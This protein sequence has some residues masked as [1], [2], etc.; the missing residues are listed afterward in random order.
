MDRV[1]SGLH[2]F[3]K[4]K[5]KGL[6]IGTAVAVVGLG[7]GAGLLLNHGNSGGTESNGAL[8]NPTVVSSNEKKTVTREDV[9]ISSLSNFDIITPKEAPDGFADASDGWNDKVDGGQTTEGPD[10]MWFVSDNFSTEG[11]VDPVCDVKFAIHKQSDTVSQV[12]EVWHG[13]TLDEIVE[14]TQAT[15]DITYPNRSSI[16]VTQEKVTD[17]KIQS[18]DGTKNY[19]IPMMKFS[20][21]NGGL[22]KYFGAAKLQSGDIAGLQVKCFD[23]H[24]S[25]GFA[26]A[27][28]LPEGSFDKLW[29][30][31]DTIKIKE[32]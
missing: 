22:V 27:Q 4:D 12:Y 21:P 31:V 5:K 13:D 20:S 9:Q 1:K 30:I 11:N 2:N 28:A 17:V 16:P 3:V 32:K 29:K 25:E 7:L 10:G 19:T 14:N 15:N 6:I 8:N 23:Q 24:A 26:G 18:S